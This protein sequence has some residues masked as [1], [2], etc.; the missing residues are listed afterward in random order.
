MGALGYY[1]SIGARVDDNSIEDIEDNNIIETIEGDIMGVIDD[2]V[3]GHIEDGD[4]K[5]V[6]DYRSIVA[7]GD[8]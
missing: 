2:G 3:M 4:R 8:L 1:N 6:G 7:L 5:G